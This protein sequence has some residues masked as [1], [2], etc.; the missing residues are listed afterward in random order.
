MVY[1]KR[2]YTVK[3]L[4]KNANVRLK[5]RLCVLSLYKTALRQWKITVENSY[6]LAT[7]WLN[8]NN[9]FLDWSVNALLDNWTNDWIKILN[10]DYSQFIEDTWHSEK[11]ILDNIGTWSEIILMKL[12]YH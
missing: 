11:Y 6:H 5:F 12:K 2:V 1:S 7:C 3:I 9:V 4:L 10:K 8:I